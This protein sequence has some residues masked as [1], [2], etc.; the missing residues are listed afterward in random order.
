MLKIGPNQ[1]LPKPKRTMFAHIPVLIYSGESTMIYEIESSENSKRYEVTVVQVG[2]DMYLH[3]SCP[4]GRFAEER[5][6]SCKHLRAVV[7]SWS[8]LPT[9]EELKF[10]LMV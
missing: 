4:H 10:G 2:D 6:E 9:E 8:G 3:C 1:Q 7:H 5:G